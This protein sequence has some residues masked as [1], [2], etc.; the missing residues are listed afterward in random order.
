MLVV[1][2]GQKFNDTVKEYTKKNRKM[3][4]IPHLVVPFFKKESF[5]TSLKGL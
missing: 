3:R 4:T 5:Y 2:E 1:P